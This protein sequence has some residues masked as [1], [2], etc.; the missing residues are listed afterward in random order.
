MHIQRDHNSAILITKNRDM[1]SHIVLDCVSSL[2][3]KLAKLASRRKN[4]DVSARTAHAQF[5]IRMLAFT[6][7]VWKSRE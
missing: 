2:L 6:R 5:V 4:C 3:R 1:K 7:A